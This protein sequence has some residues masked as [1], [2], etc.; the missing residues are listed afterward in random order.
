MVFTDLRHGAD[1]EEDD[2]RLAEDG[3]KARVGRLRLPWSRDDLR[4]RRRGRD[5]DALEA[6]GE[7]SD[8]RV[9]GARD[10]GQPKRERGDGAERER[11]DHVADHRR[12]RAGP[13][14]GGRL[15]GDAEG[16]GGALGSRAERE[17]I[18]AV[19]RVEQAS[20]PLGLVCFDPQS[21]ELR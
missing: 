15:D 4:A 17:Q 1:E 20:D 21:R 7:A 11:G 2:E 10:E 12:G 6:R 18:E 8:Q 14:A 13:G 5:G 16:A 3:R 19:E 9:D